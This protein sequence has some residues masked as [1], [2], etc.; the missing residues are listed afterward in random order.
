MA[1]E[2]PA[3]GCARWMGREEKKDGKGIA[4]REGAESNVV[5]RHALGSITRTE[6]DCPYQHVHKEIVSLTL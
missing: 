1:G 6:S 5:G 4:D 2:K 3:G